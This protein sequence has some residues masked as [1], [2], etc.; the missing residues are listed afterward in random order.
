MNIKR[1]LVSAAAAVLIAVCFSGC[2]EDI[3]YLPPRMQEEYE[4][5]FSFSYSEALNGW[6]VIS[7]SGTDAEVVFP[8]E[9]KGK[10]VVGCWDRPFMNA[11]NKDGIDPYTYVTKIT[12]PDSFKSIPRLGGLDELCEVSIP[13]GV[14]ALS[15][16][17]F[18]DCPKL[19]TIDIPNSVT[20]IG[21]GCFSRCGLISVDIPDSVTEIGKDAFKHCESL[22]DITLPDKLTSIPMGM[23][24]R[25][26]SLTSLDIP[27]SVTAIESL[28]FSSSGLQQLTLPNGLAKIGEY[29]FSSLDIVSIEIPSSVTEIGKSAFS[30]C[31]A[32]KDIK[33]GNGIT[34]IPERCFFCCHSLTEIRVP[35]GVEVIGYEAFGMGVNE[36][37]RMKSKLEHIYLPDSV[38]E[39]DLDDAGIFSL[40]EDPKVHISE[41][42]PLY[43]QAS[44]ENER[45]SKF[46]GDRWVIE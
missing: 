25:C 18:A 35:E 11:A 43:E 30:G 2:K 40:P 17:C 26:T 36:Y 9:Y 1:L 8:S 29:T 19:T 28:A 24:K 12:F 42:S 16:Y 46:T 6:E 21:N 38:K 39:F 13:D 3:S 20:S 23:L 34:E 32:L 4:N 7:Y 31:T 44:A 27:D 41:S 45:T 37:Q 33:F 22:S 5:G 10:P 14:T 15:E